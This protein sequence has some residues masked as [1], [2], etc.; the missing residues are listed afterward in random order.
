MSEGSDSD[1]RSDIPRKRKRGVI[2][3]ST[4]KPEII[5]IARVKGL[6]Y[7]NSRGQTVN[8]LKPKEDCR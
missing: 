4:Y 2:N 3:K 6:S 5:K 8:P 1:S 7:T